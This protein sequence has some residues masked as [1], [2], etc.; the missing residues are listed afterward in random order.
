MV[1]IILTYLIPLGLPIA[2]YALWVSHARKKDP[3]NPLAFFD[4]PWV[5]AVAAGMGLLIVSL[6]VLGIVD[7][8]DP[9]KKYVPSHFEDGR[10]VPGEFR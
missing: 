10:V 2:L 3:E 1:R 4:G 6:V 7:R 5:W 8:E 9:R